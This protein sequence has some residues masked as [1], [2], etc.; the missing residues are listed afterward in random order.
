[1][2]GYTLEGPKWNTS[3]I[4][5][6]FAQSTLP[7]D[8]G[9]P[10]TDPIAAAAY[11]AIV[12]QAFADWAAVSGLTF[13]QVSDSANVDIRLGFGNLPSGLLGQTSWHSTGSFFNPDVLVRLEDPGV[14]PLI[15]SSGTIIYQGTQT[16]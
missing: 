1:M 10:F 8:N 7:S 13:V 2:S 12:Q 5:W 14:D 6:S 11:Q 4:T 15:S 16:T 3:V 9:F